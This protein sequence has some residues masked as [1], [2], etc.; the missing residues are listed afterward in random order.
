MFEFVY[1][2]NFAITMVCLILGLTIAWQYKS[3][4]NNSTL[5]TT[6]SKRLEDIKD[7]L[8]NEKNNNEKLRKRNEALLKEIKELEDSHGDTSTFE[9]NLKRELRRAKAIACLTNVVGKGIIVQV[10]GAEIQETD[11][12]W[13]IN[14]L[15]AAGAQAISVNDERITATSEIRNAGNYIVINGKQFRQP[16]TIKAI[17][18]QEKVKNVLN[19][20]G[21]VVEGLKAYKLKVAVSESNNI[22]IPKAS[23]DGNAIRYDLLTP[24]D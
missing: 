21:G 13:L 10:E 15:R 2:K 7:E 23:D 3:I 8:I 20:I 4:Y 5:E 22:T 6:Q 12:L 19:M 14:E 16:F 18:E 9:N 17:A 1:K 11:L 24:V